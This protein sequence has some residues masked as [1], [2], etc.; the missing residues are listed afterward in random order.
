MK[1]LK[2]IAEGFFDADDV[3]DDFSNTTFLKSCFKS[4]DAEVGVSIDGDVLNLKC[5]SYSRVVIKNL[6]LIKKA[7]AKIINSPVYLTVEDQKIIKGF[8]FNYD[9]DDY[10][11]MAF[12]V[13]N[14]RKLDNVSMNYNVNFNCFGPIELSHCNIK[15]N[16]KECN[17]V[18]FLEVDDIK[19]NGS[20]IDTSL[21]HI[22][23]N[24]DCIHAKNLERFVSEWWNNWGDGDHLRDWYG[25]KKI[26]E[27]FKIPRQWKVKA[28]CLKKYEWGGSS[29]LYILDKS[30]YARLG[31]S[32]R[33]D[34]MVQTA[35]GW[36]LYLFD[37]NGLGLGWISSL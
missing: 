28:Y 30:T 8:E 18:D 12:V 20:V 26:D 17:E 22:R 19:S 9:G 25:R 2:Y 6:D 33:K 7:G 21:A 24:D 35:D 31:S 3:L 37:G 34:E 23:W 14:A 13:K 36:Y 11:E 10:G 32:W 29:A 27:V 5:D 1:T 16:S 15:T 4:D